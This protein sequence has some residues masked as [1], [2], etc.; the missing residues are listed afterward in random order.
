M[1][2]GNISTTPTP[3]PAGT[4]SGGIRVSVTGP[5]AIDTVTLTS[6]PYHTAPPTT[7]GDY[8]ETAQAIDS[9]GADLGAAVVVSFTIAPDV[10]ID[11]P[12]S[13]S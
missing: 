1:F 12:T 13:I 3:F 10:M 5:Q 6:A 11:V 8:V 4:V 2:E 7:P 9:N